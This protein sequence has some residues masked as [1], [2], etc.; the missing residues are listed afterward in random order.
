MLFK[1]YALPYVDDLVGSCWITQGVQPHIL[2]Q[3]C[4][5]G[6]G[7][8]GKVQEGRGVYILTANSQCCMAEMNTTL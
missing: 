7:G 8:G 2:W 1:T 6:M 3:P 5:G 4:K